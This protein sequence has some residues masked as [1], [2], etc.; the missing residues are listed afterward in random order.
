MKNHLLLLQSR[1]S[2]S[3][4]NDRM[5]E[6]LQQQIE[7]YENY[8]HT[9]NGYLDVILRDKLQTAKEN[10]ID[11]SVAVNFEDGSFMEPLDI[12]AI[13]GNAIDNA[14]EASQKL[15]AS[16]RLITVKARRVRDMLPIIIE[17]SV[18]TG[19][20]ESGRTSKPDKLLHGFGLKSINE[21]VEKY[22]GY[23][24]YSENRQLFRCISYYRSL[25]TLT[26]LTSK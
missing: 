23:A 14:I 15:P 6:S 5:I 9:G 16:E 25:K 26:Q 22:R 21:A 24:L 18:A 17:N 10:D 2:G 12:S 19:I 8:Y 4:E 13:F 20:N 1:E 11:M 3:D 7:G